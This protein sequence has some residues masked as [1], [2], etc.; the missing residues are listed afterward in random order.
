MDNESNKKV[1]N[2]LCKVET[3]EIEFD[4]DKYEENL[5][6]LKNNGYNFETEDGE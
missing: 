6:N 2:T 1:L 5:K 4:Q 3:E